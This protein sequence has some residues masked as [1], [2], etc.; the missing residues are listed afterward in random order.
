[1]FRYAGRGRRSHVKLAS[2]ATYKRS[3]SAMNTKIL[4]PAFSISGGGV[5]GTDEVGQLAG[6]P[7][8]LVKSL[9]IVGEV[10]IRS[11]GRPPS[12]PREGPTGV[13]CA[14]LEAGWG[15]R[16]DGQGYA[17]GNRAGALV[18]D[19]RNLKSLLAGCGLR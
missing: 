14:L 6:D 13:H 1:M 12:G 10:S 9:G 17:E 19:R 3:H 8:E 15:A 7:L 5:V 11:P 18:M 2:M 4:I 16:G